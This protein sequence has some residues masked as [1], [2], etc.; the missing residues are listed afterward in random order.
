MIKLQSLEI[1]GN[2]LKWIKIG[3]SNGKQSVVVNGYC[4]EWKDFSS[5]MPQGSVLGPILFIIFINDIDNNILSILS[6]FAYDT[7]VGKVV[8]NETH[9]KEFQS[10]LD[11]LYYWIKPWKMKF[12][13][14]KCVCM[15]I[16]YRNKKF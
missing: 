5:G 2:I 3:L 14:E 16:G 15:L 8:N 1:T 6:N 9:A 7:K 12:N 10:D 11:K 13:L 4:S